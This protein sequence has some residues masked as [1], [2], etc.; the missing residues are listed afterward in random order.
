M[1][2]K[3]SRVSSVS[4]D[5]RGAWTPGPWVGRELRYLELAPGA[6]VPHFLHV[7]LLEEGVRQG[8]FCG[9]AALGVHHQE[10]GNLRER[11]G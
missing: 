4:S 5:P 10:A 3:P 6:E 1:P 8:L 11:G 7:I 2:W 9:E